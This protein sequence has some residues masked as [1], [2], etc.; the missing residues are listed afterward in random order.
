M[1]FKLFSAVSN[2]FQISS[3]SARKLSEEATVKFGTRKFRFLI[4]TSKSSPLVCVSWTRAPDGGS[5][6]EKKGE[7]KKWRGVEKKKVRKWRG[8]K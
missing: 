8:G 1:S 2:D 5:G 7:K 6:V 4:F 3:D